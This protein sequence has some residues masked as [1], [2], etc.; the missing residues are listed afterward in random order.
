M[1]LNLFDYFLKQLKISIFRS[2]SVVPLICVI[3]ALQHEFV[4][5][6]ESEVILKRNWKWK[7]DHG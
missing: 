4:S 7:K 1:F 6:E 3:I 5:V 2:G